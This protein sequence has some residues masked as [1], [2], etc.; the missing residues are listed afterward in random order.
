MLV[1]CDNSGRNEGH[2]YVLQRDLNAIFQP[3]YFI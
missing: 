1:K 3:I 2:F